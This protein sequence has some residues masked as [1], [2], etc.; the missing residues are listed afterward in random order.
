MSKCKWFDKTWIERARLQFTVNNAFGALQSK[1]KNF[2]GILN[3]TVTLVWAWDVSLRCINWTRAA[4]ENAQRIK[5]ATVKKGPKRR[6]IC[7]KCVLEIALFMSKN[8]RS[9]VR[10]PRVVDSEFDKIGSETVF[11]QVGDQSDS[12]TLTYSISSKQRGVDLH[13]YKIGL[14][15]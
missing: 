10:L 1:K 7:I 15:S 13:S 11:R 8:R 14:E 3:G 9:I 6:R 4:N 2:Y 5:D 12:H